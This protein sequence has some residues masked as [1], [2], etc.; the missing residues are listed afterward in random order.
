MDFARSSRLFVLIGIVALY[1]GGGSQPIG[2]AGFFSIGLGV[3]L[4]GLSLV[5]VGRAAGQPYKAPVD[6]PLARG[7]FALAR[8]LRCN[9]GRAPTDGRC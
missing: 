3:L 6:Q 2:L 4:G 7:R 9:V 5:G 1:C 8:W